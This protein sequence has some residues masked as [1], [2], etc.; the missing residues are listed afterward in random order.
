[1]WKQWQHF[2]SRM[3]PSIQHRS[4]LEN[5]STIKMWKG[6]GK[7]SIQWFTS[8]SQHC[9]IHTRKR[10]RSQIALVPGT[11]EGIPTSYKITSISDNHLL[12]NLSALLCEKWRRQW[13]EPHLCAEANIVY[14]FN[15]LYTGYKW[16]WRKSIFFI[17]QSTFGIDAER[18]HLW[19]IIRLC[20]DHFW[21]SVCVKF[22][23]HGVS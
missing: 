10:K 3:G 5:L 14:F 7:S 23:A 19:F 22:K 15:N 13:R 6:I 8:P 4:L 18:Q 20:W 21:Y 2:S 11:S 1:M 16:N 17:L 9:C 12:L